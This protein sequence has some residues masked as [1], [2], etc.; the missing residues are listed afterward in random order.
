MLWVVLCL[1]KKKSEHR[2]WC[3]EVK[4]LSYHG[5]YMTHFE[6]CYLENEVLLQHK[7]IC[8]NIYLGLNFKK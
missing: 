5:S 1:F 8:Q 2:Q 4:L 3:R 6:I 7:D